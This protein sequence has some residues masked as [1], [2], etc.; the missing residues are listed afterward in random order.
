MLDLNITKVLNFITFYLVI[1][2]ALNWGLVGAF[3]YNLVESILGSYPIV[4]K[5]IYILV[6]VSGLYQ[7]MEKFSSLRD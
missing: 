1:I 7:V 5:A 3:D 6:A 2:G 4:V